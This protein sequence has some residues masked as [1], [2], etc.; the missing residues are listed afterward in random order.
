M[1]GYQDQ[2]EA[3]QGLSFWFYNYNRSSGPIFSIRPAGLKRHTVSL[4]L[5][6][7]AAPCVEHIQNRA[8]HDDY[9]FAYA[10]TEKLKGSFDLKINGL[11][12]EAGWQV[13]PDL[14]ISVT[15]RVSNQQSTDDIL[16][17]INS[18][19]VPLIAAMAELI[20]YE[21]EDER[22]E[23]IHS[24]VEGTLTPT[25]IQKRERSLR[26]RLL[27]LSLHGERCGVCGFVTQDIYGKELT[28]ILEVHHI[29]PIAD[30]EQ[31]RAYDPRT[32][33]IPL[34]PNC[35]RAIHRRKPALTPEE[36]KGIMKL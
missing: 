35:H 10:F 25:L 17:S 4:K 33:L 20:G 12:P 16:Q 18:M 3:R 21:D 19:M 34:C 31:P 9:A 29:E 14:K 30:I 23:D 2:A 5:G 22:P 11:Q 26:N 24:D 32:D 6:P 8:T 27:C 36:L 13:S 1:R 15:R 28:S 7:Y